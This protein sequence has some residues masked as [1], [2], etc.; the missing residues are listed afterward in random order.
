MILN[1]VVGNTETILMTS[2]ADSA[3]VSIIFYNAH[4]T[5]NAIITVYAY[6]TGFSGTDG[7]TL[8]KVEIPPEDTFIWS[9]DEKLLLQTDAVVSAKCNTAGIVTATINYLVI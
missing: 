2:I 1:S 7:T 5:N 8:F 3:I 9:S 6:P 4:P